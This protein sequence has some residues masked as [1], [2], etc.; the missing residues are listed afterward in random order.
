VTWL[1]EPI[2]HAETSEADIFN[3]IWSKHGSRDKSR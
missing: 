3:R 1:T 2:K